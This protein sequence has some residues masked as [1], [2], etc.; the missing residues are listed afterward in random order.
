MKVHKYFSPC[1]LGRLA[2]SKFNMKVH[3]YIYLP[4]T[5]TFSM[6]EQRNNYLEILLSALAVAL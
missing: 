4:M 2:T 5:A 6:R 3:I 1:L